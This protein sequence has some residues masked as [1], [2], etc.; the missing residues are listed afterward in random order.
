MTYH[1]YTSEE[2][3]YIKQHCNDDPHKVATTLNVPYGTVYNYMLQ[4]RK[5]TFPVKRAYPPQV[6]YAVY[7]RKTD[8]LVCSGS[9][10]ECANHLGMNKTTF[11]AMVCKT[12]KGQ[13]KKWD[14]YT[15]LYGDDY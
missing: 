15:E 7:L 2:L 1:R 12:R 14:V 13:I 9:A 5:N 8:E 4:F 6:Y 11:H 10:R 3:E